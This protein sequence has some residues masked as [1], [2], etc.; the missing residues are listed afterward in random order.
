MVI[1]AEREIVQSQAIAQSGIL[2]AL[3]MQEKAIL[4]S[5]VGLYRARKLEDRDAMIGIATIAQ[6]RSL[7][8]KLTRSLIAGFDASQHLTE[9]DSNA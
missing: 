9:G 5:L 3:D 2:G 1:E 4:D 8:G 6:I 7:S